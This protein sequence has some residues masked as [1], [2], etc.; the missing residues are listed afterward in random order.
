MDF[1]G[2]VDKMS[3]MTCV[4]SVEKLSDGSYGAIRI[5]TG[6]KAYID[7]IEVEDE[8]NPRMLTNHFVPNSEY[9]NYFTKDLNFED[10]CYRAA[11]KKEVLHTYVQPE[12]FDVWMNI[13]MLPLVSDDEKLGYCLYLM[14][15]T[16][17]ANTKKMSNLSQETAADVLNTCLKLRGAQDFKVAVNEVMADIRRIC[18]ARHVSLLLM[19]QEERKCTMLGQAYADTARKVGMK[20]WEDEEHYRI[21]SSWHD[22]IGGST[23]LI[24]KNEKDLQ[25][26]KE[27]NPK[28]YESLYK[29]EVKSLVLFPLRSRHEL[30]GYIWATNFEVEN[31]V[32]IKETLEVTSF[33][34]ASEVSN[35]LLLKRLHT[36]STIDLLTGVFNRNAMNNRVD[37][38]GKGE[39]EKERTLGVVFADLN[40][41]KQVNDLQGHPV[42]D[43]LLKNAAMALQNAF[44]GDEIYRAGGDEFVILLFDT[45]VEK[46]KEKV[47]HLK[48]IQGS[49]GGASFAVGF[50]FQKNAA[51]VRLALHE[52]DEAMY[53][54]KKEYYREHPKEMRG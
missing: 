39:A 22:M 3:S 30:L 9:Q 12:R 11:V 10:F 26:I 32:R 14:E 2:L 15:I 34:M 21:V 46:I 44:L 1:Q 40:G 53:A 25:L 17:E 31:A 7:S 6:N 33:I 48:K 19:D 49:Y 5:V 29:A 41:L 35:Y 28:W 45:T 8:V 47:E 54:D 20:H 13:I 38:I 16:K 27:K 50:S 52:A 42:G 24:L 23:C 18:E 51:E 37:E 4:I 36:L 43:L